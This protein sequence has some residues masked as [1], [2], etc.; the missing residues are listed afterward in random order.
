MKHLFNRWNDVRRTLGRL[1]KVL[2]LFD[3]DGTLAP[4][5]KRPE[6][7]VLPRTTRRLLAKLSQRFPGR[8]GILSGRRLSDIRAKVRIP[9]LTYAGTHGFS[10]RGPHIK[11]QYRLS[12]LRQ[13]RL[14]MLGRWMGRRQKDVSG[15]WMEDKNWTICLHYREV[16]PKNMARARSVLREWRELAH[17]RGFIVQKGLKTL[18]VFS[19]DRW[20]KG[21]ALRWIQN[22]TRAQG[23]FYVGDDTTDETVFRAGGKQ[24]VTVRVGRSANSRAAYYVTRQEESPELLQKLLS[25]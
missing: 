2:W 6:K 1:E 5:V 10:I 23:V 21:K 12:S 14:K 7:A 13:K 15:L 18:E 4:I 22:R 16:E 11:W 3:F 24:R 17:K 8:V 25:L 19:D 20:N 9:G